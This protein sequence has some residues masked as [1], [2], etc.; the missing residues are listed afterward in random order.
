MKVEEPQPVTQMQMLLRTV[1]MPADTNANGDI[2]GG[3][4]MSQ[5]DLAGGIL[6][7]EV[8]Q[9][10]TVTIAVDQ[11]VFHKPV[12]VGDV[13]CCYGRLQKS[14]TTS[15]TIELEVW[16][17]PILREGDKA[18]MQV[19]SAHFTYVAIDDEGQKRALPPENQNLLAEDSE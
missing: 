7:K 18:R 19:T 13:V 10:R 1:A 5:M 3:W 15:A 16:V 6:A 8:S 17:N 4:P 11:I 14:G 9:G 2:F 12:K